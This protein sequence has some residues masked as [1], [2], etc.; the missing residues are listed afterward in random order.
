[1]IEPTL[2]IDTPDSIDY[3][4][5]PITKTY[6]NFNVK[7]S[8]DARICLSTSLNEDSDV[9]EIIIGGWGNT[10]SAIKRNRIEP[11]V[12][13]AET[14]NIMS[15]DEICFFWMQWSCDGLIAIGHEDDESPFLSYCDKE[16][17]SINYIGVSTAW[18]ATG[19]WI[20]DGSY[21]TA[22]AV[23][24]Q[25]LETSSHW[26]DYDPELG[27][28]R[29]AVTGHEDGLYIGRSRHRHSVT[30][31]GVRGS[32]CSIS[33]GGLGHEKHEFQLLCGKDV[34]WLKCS[35]GAVPLLAL[36][37]GETE[38]GNALFIGRIMHNGVA[39]IGKIQPNHQVCYVALHGQEVAYAEYEVLVLHDFP[40]IEC[41]GR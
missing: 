36:P 22:P 20:L 13:E 31:G 1:M 37:A 12:A 14:P 40:A 15:D 34:G 16:P 7:A 33:W 38:D 10:M 35:R 11:D 19:E 24:S 8:H 25:L 2:K 5:F 39:H 32:S 4:Y 27:L 6:I 41:I 30:P 23:R 18:G 29:G 28:P 26:V 9:Y 3:C 17:F 21:V